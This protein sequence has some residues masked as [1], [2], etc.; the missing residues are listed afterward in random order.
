MG[1]YP[2]Y[3]DSRLDQFCIYCG[4][5]PNTRE[6]VPPKMLL[7]KPYPNFLH[8]VPVCKTCNNGFSLNEEYLSCLIECA[9]CGSA[10][11]KKLFRN[12]VKETLIAKKSLNRRLKSSI[13]SSL[14]GYVL[15]AVEKQ[16]V[17]D[18]IIKICQ[19]HA[20]YE[21]SETSL[22]APSKVLVK[23]INQ[24]TSTEK[25]KF[26]SRIK[27]KLLPEV[28]SRFML[29]VLM[30]LSSNWNHVQAGQYRFMTGISDRIVVKI[31]ISEYLACEIVWDKNEI[32]EE[33][34]PE[35]WR[36]GNPI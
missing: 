14:I 9:R 13:R 11:P 12:K 6:H 4:E 29:K 5:T 26:E 22:G 19:G 30:D 21:L 8:V 33:D 1:Y 34:I 3:S 31:V 28:G 23:P 25:K 15:T 35:F 20:A 18:T 24:M 2:K 32:K 7:N 10:E 36:L 17:K 16:R 27:N